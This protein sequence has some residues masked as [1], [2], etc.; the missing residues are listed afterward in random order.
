MRIVEA[1]AAP[2]SPGPSGIRIKTPS[3]QAATPGTAQTPMTPATPSGAPPGSDY[4]TARPQ[5]PP[6]PKWPAAGPGAPPSVAGAQLTPTPGPSNAVANNGEENGAEV[7][8]A[9]PAGAEV[10]VGGGSA[11]AKNNAETTLTVQPGEWPF[12][13]AVE[14]LSVDL[15]SPMWETRHGAALGLREIFKVQGSGGGKSLSASKAEND[16]NH[17]A[18]CDDVAIKLLCV[19]A[20]DRLG[21]FVFDQVIAPVRETASQTLASL[22]P[23]MPFSSVASVH[24]ILLEM[25]RQDHLDD[26]SSEAQTADSAPQKGKRNYVWEVRHAGL[27]GLK[28]EVAVRR[29]LLILDEQKVTV[30]AEGDTKPD[31]DQLASGETSASDMLRDVVDVAVLGLRDEDDDVRA[32]AAATLIPIADI[33]IERLPSKISSVLDQL[34]DCLGDLK[35]DLSSSTGGVMDLLA[36]LVEYP[37]VID[38]LNAP[39][40]ERSLSALIPRLYPFF[41]HTITSVRLSVLNALK[42]FLTVPSIPRD[43][44]DDR[45]LRLLFQNLVVEERIPIREAS[46][47]AW[48]HAFDIVGTNAELLQTLGPHLPTLFR[49]IMTPLG[50]PIDFSLFFKPSGAG[51]HDGS[52]HNVDKGILAQDLALVGVDTVIRGRIGAAAALGKALARWPRSVSVS[53]LLRIANQRQLTDEFLL[54]LQNDEVAFGALLREYLSSSSALQKCLAAAIVQE[55]A[56]AVEVQQQAVK[57][58]SEVAADL[59]LRLIAALEAPPPATYAEMAIM[60]QRLQS[61]CQGLY[62][63]FARDA[64]LAKGKIPALPTTVDPLGHLVDAFTIDTAK[65]VAQQGFDSLLIQVGSKAKK[66]ALPL[67]QDRQ[68]KLIASIGFYQATKNKQDIQVYASVAGAVIALQVMPA[69][70][71]PVIRSIMNSVKVRSNS[72]RDA[73][74]FNGHSSLT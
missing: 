71:N 21:D 44:V 12:R 47:E 56:E 4:L 32:V 9:E 58:T 31:A 7:E 25:I 23:H 38:E 27:L 64:K 19:F 65:H 1:S 20:L 55:W 57:D 33:I 40:N 60:L 6:A 70:L 51:G 72:C 63:S 61:E 17:K 2:S 15:F 48:S 18:W 43:W 35:D 45:V 49:I 8:P 68:H 67:L 11:N 41:R 36:K 24:R 28:Y 14:V 53:C 62:N 29:D 5:P 3:W 39:K 59:S 30:K 69:K 54:R 16:A 73:S 13:L 42:V 50:S 34:W 37:R 52:R 74:C 10:T 22:L 46:S 66:A 26:G